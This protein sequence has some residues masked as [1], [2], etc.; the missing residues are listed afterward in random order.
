VDGPVKKAIH[1]SD[2]NHLENIQIGN[3]AIIE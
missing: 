2:F 1:H 3:E